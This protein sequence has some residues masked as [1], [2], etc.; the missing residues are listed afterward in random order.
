MRRNLA[1]IL[2]PE[3]RAEGYEPGDEAAYRAATALADRF[4]APTIIAVTD[5]LAFLE[6]VGGQMLVTTLRTRLNSAG[7]PVGDGE[8]GEYRTVGISVEYESR[9]A[10]VEQI[11]RPAEVFGIEVRDTSE[12]PTQVETPAPV[13][14]DEPE[15]LEAAEAA[16]TEDED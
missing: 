2:F 16:D 15:A 12:P 13:S 6:R 10:K 4:D 8:P 7:Q 9:D 5:A 14:H 1:E 11:K 3:N